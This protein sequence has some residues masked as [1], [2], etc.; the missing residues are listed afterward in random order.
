MADDIDPG[1]ASGSS[2]PDIHAVHGEQ[3]SLHSKEL[4]GMAQRGTAV[5]SHSFKLGTAVAASEQQ[6]PDIAV[7]VP[8]GQQQQLAGEL[9]ASDGCEGAAA[10]GG[11][12]HALQAARSVS[13]QARQA[14]GWRAACSE[15]LEAAAAPP[16]SS[17]LAGCSAGVAL[18][19]EQHSSGELQVAAAGAGPGCWYQDSLH[20]EGQ[21]LDSWATDG[22]QDGGFC[23]GGQACR[24]A[25]SL[26]VQLREPWSG[27]VVW[28]HTM[29]VD[30]LGAQHASPSTPSA[31]LQQAPEA[32]G[33]Q[34]ACMQEHQ[35]SCSEELSAAAVCTE[36]AVRHSCPGATTQMVAAG[37]QASS[38]VHDNPS[39]CGGGACLL[40]LTCSPA[41]K[42]LSGGIISLTPHELQEEVQLGPLLG[43]GGA[44]SVYK[45]TWQGRQVAVKL[46]HPSQQVQ[47]GNITAFRR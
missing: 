24:E 47:P 28:Q 11:L 30:Q 39:G 18:A 40:P 3:G 35:C 22:P 17:G 16:L 27:A 12:A 29:Q 6:E 8:P 7:W 14:A 41:T 42:A 5:G 43:V 4:E 34:A 9:T 2:S 36:G 20:S 25:G 21:H 33:A 37:Q 44:G 38:G 10:E 19:A 32:A 15:L 45:A 1:C 26:T 13:P 31:E 46:A 23:D